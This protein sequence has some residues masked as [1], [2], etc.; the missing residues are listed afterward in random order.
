MPLPSITYLGLSYSFC[1]HD[2]YERISLRLTLPCVLRSLQPRLGGK[3][4]REGSR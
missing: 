4:N 1:Q 3:P 2:D